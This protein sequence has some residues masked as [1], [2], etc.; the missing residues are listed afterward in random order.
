MS[1]KFKVGEKVRV[2]SNLV[3]GKSYGDV[4]YPNHMARNVKDKTLT[5]S[6]QFIGS[7]SNARYYVKEN[8]YAYSDDMLEFDDG[9]DKSALLAGMVVIMR[10]GHEYYVQHDAKGEIYLY[11]EDTDSSLDMDYFKDDLTSFANDA[12]DIMEIYGIP[13]YADDFTS[14][15]TSTRACICT[16]KEIKPVTEVTL[17]EVAEKFGIDVSLLRIKEKK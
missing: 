16:R 2:K 15:D 1:F 4:F 14:R 12:Y 11:D 13:D 6:S 17:G 5:I 8:S 10:N 3:A 7:D 9:L